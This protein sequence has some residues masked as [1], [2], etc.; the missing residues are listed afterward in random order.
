MSRLANTHR[1][2]GQS[3]AAVQV[4][5]FSL[6]G[7]PEEKYTLG[8]M[9]RLIRFYSIGT[10]RADHIT[11]TVTHRQSRAFKRVAGRGCG[12]AG[13]GIRRVSAAHTV[14]SGDDKT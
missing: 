14:F 5:V 10:T 13:V 12:D 11:M 7:L 9:E 1:P 4:R 2:F 3:D 8:F 6:S